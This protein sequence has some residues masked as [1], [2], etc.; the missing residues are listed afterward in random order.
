MQIYWA[1]RFIDQMF[2]LEKKIPYSLLNMTLL[3]DK[4]L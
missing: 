4:N 3:R 1:S 2:K